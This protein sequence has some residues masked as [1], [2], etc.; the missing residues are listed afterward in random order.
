MTNE[1]NQTF[2]GE[3][4]GRV[5]LKKIPTGIEGLDQ[6]LEG[7]FPRGRTSVVIGAPGSGKTVLGLEFLYRGALAGEPGIFIGFEEPAEEVRENAATLGWD[8]AALESQGRLFLLQSGIEPDAVL[9]GEFSLKG[10]LGIISGK[11]REMGA[12]RIVLD[13]MDVLLRLFDEPASV[14]AQLHLLNGWLKDSGL[15]ALL[16]LKPRETE[17]ARE[18]QEFFY[19]MADCVVDLEVRVVA[20][21][22]TRRLRVVKYRGASFGRNEYPYVIT[23]DGFRLVPVTGLLLDHQPF[24][25]KLPTGIDRLDALLEGGYFRGSCVVVAGEPGTGKTLVASA[26]SARACK[27]GERVF[28]LSFE[29]SA[30]ALV[31]NVRSA[32][33]DLQPHREAGLLDIEALMP[34][35]MGAEEHLLFLMDRVERT[36]PQHVI[37][38]AISACER[39]GG[40]RA[41]MEYLMRTL[42]FLKTRGIT[43]F[44]TNQT[45]GAKSQLEISGNDIS[46]MIDTVIFITYVQGDG[47]TNRAIQVVKGRGM[48]HSNQFREFVITKQGLMIQ[49]FYAGA[50]GV[51]TGTARKIRE[52]ADA[53]ELERLELTRRAK[54]AEIESLKARLEAELQEAQAELAALDMEWKR[55][56]EDRERIVRMRGG[57]K[58]GPGPRGQ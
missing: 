3:M 24:G 27:A 38:D 51:L 57:E 54:R 15:T 37:L 22:A 43:V 18:F 33:V 40:K 46:S 5:P 58:N 9:S 50:G 13:A 44:L 35:A 14:R 53:L 10:L 16:T 47:E 39:M 25:D 12:R 2:A 56:R 55:V 7:G 34:E 20:Q 1:R 41:A 28:Y 36:D 42:H 23:E 19:S 45:S 49:D 21:V 26:F 17:P 52:S 32:G 29:E 6:I 48:A 4:R 11:A 8:L 30:E 31:Q